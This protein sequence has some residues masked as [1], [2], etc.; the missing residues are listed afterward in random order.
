MYFT[1]LFDKGTDTTDSV[2]SSLKSHPLLVT[3]VAK[4]FYRILQKDDFCLQ[5]V[6]LS[7]AADAAV[8]ELYNQ[9][10]KLGKKNK[11]F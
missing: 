8:E 6:G 2:Q 3:P 5:N 7:P 11:I 1:D 4:I 9:K 10:K